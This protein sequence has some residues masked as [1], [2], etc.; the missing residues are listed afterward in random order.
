[1]GGR[2]K[3]ERRKRKRKA[4]GKARRSKANEALV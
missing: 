3:I 4:K 2:T 1:V